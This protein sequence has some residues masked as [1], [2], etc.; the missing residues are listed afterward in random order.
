MRLGLRAI[1]LVAALICFVIAVFS[2]LHWPDWVAG[3]LALATGAVLVSE[4]GWDRSFSAPGR[5]T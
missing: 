1:L 4:M 5:R 3:G 2:D